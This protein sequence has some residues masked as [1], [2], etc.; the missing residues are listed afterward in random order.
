VLE[1]T[2]RNT[3]HGGADTF[4]FEND[5]LQAYLAHAAAQDVGCQLV[6]LQALGTPLV[7]TGDAPKPKAKTAGP[8][9]P[10]ESGTLRTPTAV[11]PAQ[12]DPAKQP[13]PEKK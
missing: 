8:G 13:Q 9:A 2:I 5:G 6:S 12:L 10:R 11:K 1:I 4:R 7:V 3:E